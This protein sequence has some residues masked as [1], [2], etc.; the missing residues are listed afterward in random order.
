MMATQRAFGRQHNATI[1]PLPSRDGVRTGPAPHRRDSEAE[2]GNPEGLADASIHLVV[3]HASLVRRDV[4]F[5]RP[6]IAVV[7]EPA[8]VGSISD[9]ALYVHGP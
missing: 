8:S 1:A 9:M 2:E 3:R 6:R 5:A 7:D 4:E